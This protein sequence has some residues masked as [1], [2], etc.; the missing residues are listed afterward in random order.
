[1]SKL[2]SHARP[3]LAMAGTRRYLGLQVTCAKLQWV[4]VNR[5]EGTAEGCGYQDAGS[6]GKRASP[7]GEEQWESQGRLSWEDAFM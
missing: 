2:G 5:V 1:M 6:E 7:D 3:V 4:T